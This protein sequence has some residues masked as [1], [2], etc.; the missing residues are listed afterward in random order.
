[1]FGNSAN[2]IASYKK[3]ETDIAVASADPHHLVQL[4]FDGA[5]QGIAM[6]R[7]NMTNGNIAEKGRFISQVIDIINNGLRASLNFDSGGD[8]TKSLDALYKY[9]TTRLIFAN[10]R[11]DAAILDEISSLLSEIGS[12]WSQITPGA[13]KS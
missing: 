2:A 4:L 5:I 10:L 1:M 6:A 12:A 3:V 7:I 9:A 13:P 11:N 8:I